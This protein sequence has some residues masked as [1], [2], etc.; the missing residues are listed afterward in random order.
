VIELLVLLAWAAWGIAA[1]VTREGHRRIGQG[2]AIFTALMFLI[3]FPIIQI[4]HGSVASEWFGYLQLCAEGALATLFGIG[5]SLRKLW[6]SSLFDGFRARMRGRDI[7]EAMRAIEAV[8]DQRVE[9]TNAGYRD[10]A[11][12]VRNRPKPS[13]DWGARVRTSLGLL[14]ALFPMIFLL[15]WGIGD[16]IVPALIAGIAAI[17]SAS[18][19]ILR[20]VRPTRIAVARER[21]RVEIEA[22][23]MET[24][25]VQ[26]LAEEEAAAGESTHLPRELR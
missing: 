26:K 3:A 17:A 10:T 11:V 18:I 24:E 25:L 7:D 12:V 20:G 15:W 14:A 6:L 5:W 19:P 4:L 22:E 2:F 1:L 9:Q 13:K 16:T 8:E 21:V 23:K